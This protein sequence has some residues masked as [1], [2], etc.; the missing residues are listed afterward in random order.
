GR[1]TRGERLRP[2][3]MMAADLGIAVGT[4]RRA[5]SE[6]QVRGLVERRQGSGNYVSG[7]AKGVGIYAFFRLELPGGGGVPTAE[8][9]SVARLPK[10]AAAPRLGPARDAHR[11]RRI[12]LLSGRPAALEEVWL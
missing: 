2:E 5:L 1:L 3:R 7:D 11:I 12:R 4:L 9:L 10:P 8:V 6:L